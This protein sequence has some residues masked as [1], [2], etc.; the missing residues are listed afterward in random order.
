MP[1]TIR[2]AE[3]RKFFDHGWLKT[4]HTFSF[5]N[6]YDPNFMGF[7]DLRVIN[8]DRVAPKRGFP[9]HSHKDMEIISIVLEGALAHQDDTGTESILKKD[10]LQAMSAGSGITH[11]EYNPSEKELV[12]F[13]QIWILP[14]TN[15]IP[16]RYQQVATLPKKTNEWVLLAAKNG[17]KNTLQ[18]QQDVALYAIRLDAGKTA[19]RSTQDKRQDK[20]YGW[21][22]VID[23]TLFISNENQKD[24]L[25]SGDGVAIDP[26][27]KITLS[28]T[29]PTR[30]LFFD[31]K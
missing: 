18:I 12:H 15:G 13:L 29:T 21:L 6:Y 23:G 9:P 28:A 5:G 2:R 19:Q 1:Y 7:R 3:E 30:L 16:P 14:D 24:E 4:Y 31:L 25:H 8:E 22:Q 10:E 26:A 11:S 20:C 27:T 17:P